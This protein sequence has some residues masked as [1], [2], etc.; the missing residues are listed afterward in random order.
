MLHI[1][2]FIIV[3]GQWLPADISA[4][5]FDAWT[6]H[7]HHLQCV[8]CCAVWWAIGYVVE[9]PMTMQYC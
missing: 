1:G 6:M 7:S 9:F 4:C 3:N 8:H 5:S 2:Y